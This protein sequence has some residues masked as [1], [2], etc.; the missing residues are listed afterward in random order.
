MSKTRCCERSSILYAPWCAA[1]VGGALEPKDFAG[2][3]RVCSRLRHV[4]A[5]W[6]R[7]QDKQTDLSL[8]SVLGLC[9][10]RGLASLDVS[11]TTCL[12]LCSFPLTLV[13]LKLEFGKLGPSLLGPGQGSLPCLRT[14]VLKC[15]GWQGLDASAFFSLANQILSAAPVV[16]TVTLFCGQGQRPCPEEQQTWALL[17]HSSVE[18]L[19]IDRSFLGLR[20]ASAAPPRFRHLVLGHVDFS[21]SLDYGSDSMDALKDLELETLTLVTRSFVLTG[22][23]ESLAVGPSVTTLVVEAFW[24]DFG[25]WTF[26][27]LRVLDM[28]GCELGALAF[29]QANFP[30]LDEARLTLRHRPKGERCLAFVQTNQF[31]QLSL[32]VL[33]MRGFETDNCEAHRKPWKGLDVRALHECERCGLRLE[34]SRFS[35][36]QA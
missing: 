1:L 31:L 11:A 32:R 33:H 27:G 13:E 23:M 8:A 17:A 6:S 3:R 26:A 28:H 25:R 19:A 34:M 2:M 36:V 10:V 20:P 30:V 5:A 12:D 4:K 29:M 9:V 18:H 21:G 22:Q 7:L 35:P 16:S 24:I 15:P 14:L